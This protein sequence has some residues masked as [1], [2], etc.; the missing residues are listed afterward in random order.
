M[1]QGIDILLVEDNPS[2]AEMTI[3][4][5]A[6]NHLANK[7]LHVKNGA[8]AL[9]FL[10]AKD[11]YADRQMD[12]KPKVIL[13]DL[14]MPKVNGIEVLRAIRADERT[15]AIPVVMLTSSKEDPDIQEC[16]SLNVNSYVV[17]PVEFD[18]FQ[19]AISGLGLFW[20]IINQQPY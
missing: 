7:L 15:K 17:K 5:L 6:K 19:K 1:Y 18:D 3:H 2:D 16:Y 9:D 10:F 11:K 8:E 4:A 14:K 12:H 13:L 20:L